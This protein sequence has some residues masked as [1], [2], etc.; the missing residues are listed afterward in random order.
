MA[1][2]RVKICGIRDVESAL[3]AVEAGADALGFVFVESSIRNIDPDDAYEI[4]GYL[5]PFVTKVGLFFD[6]TPEEIDDLGDAFPYDL[7][8]LHGSEDE[9]IVREIREAAGVPI[10]KAIRFEADTIEREFQRWNQVN[11]IDALLVDGS[12]GGA[13]TAFDW[14]ALAKHIGICDHPL[15][16]AGGLTPENVAEAIRVVRPYAVDVSSGVE[17]ERGVKS[18]A[19]IGAFCRAVAGTP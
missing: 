12:A 5:P 8:Q 9:S 1:R 15:V 4:A 19:L 16:L 3:A 14:T 10:L 18:A 7:V 11:E 17:S 2:T 13:G 6:A